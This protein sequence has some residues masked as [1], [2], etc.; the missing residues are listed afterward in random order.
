MT[1]SATSLAALLAVGATLVAGCGGDDDGAAATEA[2]DQVEIA[3][4]AY[5]PETVTVPAGTELT[6]TNSDGAAHTATADD[7]AFDTGT[8][9]EGDSATAPLDE[10]G[11]YTYFCRFH[12]FMNG[13]VEVQ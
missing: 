13:T 9:D 8:L 7:G 5:S 10:P 3:E 11:T 12:P 4:F 2:E 6:W 1:V